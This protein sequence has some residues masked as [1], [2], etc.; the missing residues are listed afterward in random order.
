M[1]LLFDQ[2]LAPSLVAHLEQL[3][4]GSRHVY[5]LGLGGADDRVVWEYAKQ[6]G[7]AVVT[8][9]ADFHEMSLARGA[10]PKVV[11][12][13]LGNCPTGQVVRLLETNYR[14]LMDFDSLPDATFIPLG[15][16]GHGTPV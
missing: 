4:P 5:D 16:S 8:K 15:L 12:I 6:H 9:D 2:N 3:F 7:F 1:K 14:R 13:R 10:P 11:W